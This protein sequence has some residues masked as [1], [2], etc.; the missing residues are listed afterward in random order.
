MGSEKRFHVV[1]SAIVFASIFASSQAAPI[2]DIAVVGQNV[3]NVTVMVCD[4]AG[5]LTVSDTE[6]A[7]EPA[8][9]NPTS[10]SATIAWISDGQTS[11]AVYYGPTTSLGDSAVDGS[12]QSI[13]YVTLTGLEPSTV[14]YF[15]V[16]TGDSVDNNG[17]AH[18]TFST[19]A[20]GLGTPHTLYGQVVRQ[21]DSAFAGR[22][23]VRVMAE[24][25]DQAS[26]PL[27]T[28]CDESGYWS[29][30]LSNL[31]DTSSNDVFSHSLGDSLSVEVFADTVSASYSGLAISDVSP[32]YCGEL[33]VSLGCCIGIRGDLNDDGAVNISDMTYL[34]AFLFS[35]GS[36][37]VCEEEG[38]VNGDAAINISDM[39]YLVAFLFSGGA[40]PADCP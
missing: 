22:I 4:G 19:A 17:G 27:A 8:V 24:S 3:D 37:P 12:I 39:T 2:P 34:V 40:P 21:P 5:N 35:G 18:Y 16:R 31:K 10:S 26:Y 1:L 11:G 7:G 38:D 9:A 13:H 32:Q 25:D 20:I 15:D 30:N 36:P 23:M 28:L 6:L 29:V 14:Y 33:L